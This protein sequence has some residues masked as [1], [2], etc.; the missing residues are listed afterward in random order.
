VFPPMPEQ[1]E[2]GP[3]VTISD[4]TV[5]NGFAAPSGYPAESL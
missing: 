4:Y 5:K 3:I 2:H 1:D